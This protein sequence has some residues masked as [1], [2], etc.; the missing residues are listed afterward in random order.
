MKVEIKEGEVVNDL[1]GY[2]G[3]KIIQDPSR[4]NFSLD[5]TVLAHFVTLKK[6]TKKILDLCTGNGPIP[7]ML[8]LRTKAHIGGVEL[9]TDSASQAMRSVVINDLESQITIYER[10]LIHVNETVG[11]GVYDV[12]TCNPP[13]FKVGPESNLNKNDALTMARH[14][15]T[16]T[17]EEIVK[18]AQMLLKPEG[19]FAMVHRPD[20][21]VEIIEVMKKYHIE[22]KRLRFIHPRI[23]KEA[24]G[25]LIEGTFR[26]KPGGLRLLAPLVVYE[27][28]TGN[29]T[30]E[31]L[32]MFN[33]KKKEEVD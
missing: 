21:L 32:E 27:G 6:D 17:L 33:M 20:R 31:I 2:E 18:E 28:E 29:Y 25:I 9:Q 13:Y 11:A 23:S 14:E 30:Q 7:L 10:N 24:N 15:V 4:F 19:K 16:V 8:T 5:S 22:P 3:L 26:G 12:V 1:L